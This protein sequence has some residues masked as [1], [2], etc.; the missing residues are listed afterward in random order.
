[1]QR[2]RAVVRVLVLL[3]PAIQKKT[4]LLPPVERK[5]KI[6]RVVGGKKETEVAVRLECCGCGVCERESY[7]WL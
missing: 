5:R 6:Q 7:E 3:P 1:M 2:P 4:E